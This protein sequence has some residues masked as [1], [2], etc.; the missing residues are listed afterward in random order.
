M[1]IINVISIENN[2]ISNIKSFPIHEEQLSHDVIERAENDFENKVIGIGGDL[3]DMDVFFM[4]GYYEC[5]TT[6]RTVSIVWT[7]I[8]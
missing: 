6:N 1:R 2:L 8:D 4:D 7:Y 3:N 5:P